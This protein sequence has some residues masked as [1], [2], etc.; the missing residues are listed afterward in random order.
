MATKTISPEEAIK[1]LQEDCDKKRREMH[2]LQEK[3][4]DISYQKVIDALRHL[5][6][7]DYHMI[8]EETKLPV[9]SVTGRVK[10]LRDKAIVDV[11]GSHVGRYGNVVS[12]Y[13]MSE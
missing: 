6:K 11:A 1:R 3:I 12:L 9:T 4:D 13:M 10:E 5:G 7:A 2:A 8:A